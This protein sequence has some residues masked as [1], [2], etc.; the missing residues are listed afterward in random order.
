MSNLHKLKMTASSGLRLLLQQGVNL[1][2]T[3]ELPLREVLVNGVGL[4][5]DFVEQEVETV[6]LDGHPVD[7]IDAQYVHDGARISLASGLP[8]AAGIAMRRNSPYA[9][10]RGAITAGA[11]QAERAPCPGTVAVRLFGMVMQKAADSLLAR[12]VQAQAA[13][14]GQILPLIDEG[15]YWLDGAPI[16]KA[17][18]M[19]R[20]AHLGDATI[21]VQATT[22]QEATAPG[23]PA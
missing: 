18:L 16:S 13:A 3:V 14:V 9:A 21:D 5:P 22:P 19:G 7:D 10:L 11:S 1:A 12:G 17:D 20:L 6:F 2:V 4:P 15:A 23:S 8:G